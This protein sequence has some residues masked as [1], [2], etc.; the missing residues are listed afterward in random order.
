MV[1]ARHRTVDEIKDLMEG[2][3]RIVL[4]R[5]GMPGILDDQLLE[6]T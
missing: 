4:E 6:I 3:L 2:V 5:N 1:M